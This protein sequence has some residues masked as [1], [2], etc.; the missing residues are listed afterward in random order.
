MNAQQVINSLEGKVVVGIDEVGRGCWAG[1]LVV[2]AVIIDKPIKDLADSKNLA[3][4]MRKKISGD[5]RQVCTAYSTGWVTAAEIDEL[6]LTLATTLA[7]KRATEN[8]SEYDLILIDGSINY[9]PNNPKSLNLI[10]ADSL[11]PAVSAASILA[12]VARD[13]YME[14]QALN[15][16]NYGFESNVGY[17]TAKHKQA[18]LDHGIT[19]L[20]RKSYKPVKSLAGLV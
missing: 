5:I 17:G 18:I 8:I 11:L 14:E 15:Y 9:L 4:A 13:E 7:I 10:K 6:G 2:G 16:R 19:P 20:H 12:K 1:P 3:K